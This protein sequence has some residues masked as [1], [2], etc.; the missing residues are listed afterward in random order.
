MAMKNV[1]S[2]QEGTMSVTRYVEMILQKVIEER[3][4]AKVCLDGEEADKAVE[5]VRLEGGTK[6]GERI[7][8]RGECSPSTKMV[9]PVLNVKISS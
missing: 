7:V 6:M 3:E 4:R 5:E 8:R 2:V 9:L 1:E